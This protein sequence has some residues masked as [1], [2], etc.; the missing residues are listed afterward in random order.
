MKDYSC[1]IVQLAL[2]VKQGKIQPDELSAKIRGALVIGDFNTMIVPDAPGMPD[3]FPRLQIHTVRGYRLTSS[4]ARVDFF[5]DLPLGVD[6]RLLGEF[7]QNCSALLGVLH[8]FGCAYS[9]IGFVKTYFSADERAEKTFIDL[10]SKLSSDDVSE[11]QFS[12][13][14]KTSI[15][16]YSC[17]DMFSFTSAYMSGRRGIVTVRDIN[18]DPNVD[19]NLDA[20]KAE[21]L[22]TEFN[23][24]SGKDSIVRFTGEH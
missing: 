22:I 4:N 6:E 14:K 16:G 10:V 8:G 1:H 20:E 13:T 15:S 9:R 24:L 3:E 23:F 2:F 17:N 21:S 19:L 7:T 11:V 12:L 5:L 18:T